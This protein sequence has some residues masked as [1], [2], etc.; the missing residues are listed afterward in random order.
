MISLADYKESYEEQE[1]DTFATNC[2]IPLREWQIFKA[3]N[4][5]VSP[6][7]ISKKI[8]EFAN[9]Y[10]IHPA[11]VLGRYQH[12]FNIFDNGRGFDRNIG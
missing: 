2:L 4:K 8:R 3:R 7:A 10:V 11:I 9:E 12:E 6:Y 1:A 5:G